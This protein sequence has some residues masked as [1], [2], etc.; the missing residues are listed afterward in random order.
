VI[1]ETLLDAPRSFEETRDLHFIDLHMLVM[2]GARE[3]TEQEYDALLVAAGFPSG[4]VP[5]VATSWN[6]IETTR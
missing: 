1:V 4:S 5:D 3:R 2:F 6:V